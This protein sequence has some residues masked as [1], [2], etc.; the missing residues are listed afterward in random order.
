MLM[1]AATKKTQGQRSNDFCWANEG[2]LVR[3]GSVC[4]GEHD[5]DGPCGC[6]RS[7]VGLDSHKATTT[8]EVIDS[9]LD[10][11]EIVEMFVKSHKDCGWIVNQEEIEIMVDTLGVVAED[12]GVGAVPEF[13]ADVFERRN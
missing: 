6:N 10:R 9:P 12:F 1:L 8:I 2:E 3:P 4:D 13:R 7:M 5:P 11:C